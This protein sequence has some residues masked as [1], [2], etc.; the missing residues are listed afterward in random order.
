MGIMVNYRH[1][2]DV[3]GNDSGMETGSG[4]DTP[5][6]GS[7]LPDDADEMNV[8]ELDEKVNLHLVLLLPMTTSRWATQTQKDLR[9]RVQL[10]LFSRRKNRPSPFSHKHNNSRHHRN[11]H[12]RKKPSSLQRHLVILR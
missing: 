4:I 10:M 12:L 1:I 5:Q 6:Q 9:R 11:H 2:M 8:D 3:G 7:S